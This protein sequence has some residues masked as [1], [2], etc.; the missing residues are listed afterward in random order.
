MS[1]IEEFFFLSKLP[2]LRLL[3]KHSNPS[4]Q[5]PKL[6]DFLTA[7]LPALQFLDMDRI[8]RKSKEVELESAQ[9]PLEG[10]K[11]AVDVKVMLTQAKAFF[12]KDQGIA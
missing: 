11:V 2:K 1:I 6:P 7:I 8:E 4:D 9:S 3:V 5:K 10:N 12:K